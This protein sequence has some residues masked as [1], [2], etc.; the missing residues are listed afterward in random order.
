MN[1]GLF[2]LILNFTF[3]ILSCSGPGNIQNQNLSWLYRKDKQHFEATFN[4]WHFSNDSSRLFVS[5]DP[6]DFLYKR[7]GDFFTAEISVGYRLVESYEN[8][9][10][11]DS[12]SK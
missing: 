2:F 12:S 7:S 4:V 6:K 11:I 10:V 9:A 8:P 3:L 5:L 1:R